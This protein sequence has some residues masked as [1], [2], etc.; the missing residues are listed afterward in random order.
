[1]KLV[2]HI[3]NHEH[4]FFFSLSVQY[5]RYISI[6]STYACMASTSDLWVT[7]SIRCCTCTRTFLGRA[8][9]CAPDTAD[10]C[11][12]RPRI[13]TC[14]EDKLRAEKNQQKKHISQSSRMYILSSSKS[15]LLHM[16][17]RIGGLSRVP[18]LR[19]IKLPCA[20]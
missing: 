13:C 6:V 12:I 14:P 1:M 7:C 15:V 18:R 5:K 9:C 3:L 8:L 17:V 16:D 19:F 4:V 11:R 2:D 20:R 10:T